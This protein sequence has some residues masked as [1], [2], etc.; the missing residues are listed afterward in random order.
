MRIFVFLVFVFLFVC[1]LDEGEDG[2]EGCFG[3]GV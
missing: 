1:F 2:P 3:D